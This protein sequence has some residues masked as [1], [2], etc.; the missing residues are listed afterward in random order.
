M[1]RDGGFTLLELL[2]VVAIIGTIAAIVVPSLLQARLAGNEASA[3]GSLRAINSAEATFAASCGKGSYA[4]TLADLY[5]PPPGAGTGFIS[6]DLF[7]NGVLKSGYLVN[8]A[9]NAGA[10]ELLAAD[11]ACNANAAATVSSYFAEA[12]PQ[13]PGR[14]GQRSFA[15]D[16]RASIYFLSTGTAIPVGMAGTSVLQ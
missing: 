10:V 3:I 11:A 6:A 9:A 5:T 14:S 13:T 16:T 15:T 7:T 4:Q 8:L 2:M 1:R 12:H